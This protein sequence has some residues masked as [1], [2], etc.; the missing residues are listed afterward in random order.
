MR[1][2][3]GLKLLIPW[4]EEICDSGEYSELIRWVNRSQKIFFLSWIHKSSANWNASKSA[5]FKKWAEYKEK[6]GEKDDRDLKAAF[7]NAFRSKKN[8][9]TLLV[10]GKEHRIWQILKEPIKP[11]TRETTNN[12][13]NKRKPRQKRGS[14]KNA[15][16][17]PDDDISFQE[18]PPSSSSHSVFQGS[19]RTSVSMNDPTYRIPSPIAHSNPPSP[20]YNSMDESFYGVSSP[21]FPSSP[22]SPIQMLNDDT[23]H[24]AWNSFISSPNGLSSSMSPAQEV[25]ALDINDFF[26]FEPEQFQ[27]AN[28]APEFSKP[29]A[30][31]F[32]QTRD[33]DLVSH[34]NFFEIMVDINNNELSPLSPKLPEPDLNQG[35]LGKVL[36]MDS[37]EENIMWNAPERIQL[38]QLVEGFDSLTEFTCL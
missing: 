31:Q 36:F 28:Q 2:A 37:F 7:R 33:E 16:C 11:Q 22:C 20:A 13:N 19:F 15:K 27:F 32:Y 6:S 34:Q 24:S 10:K 38:E 29:N 21:H 9:L 18:P 17:K 25:P 5:V 8:G 12:T 35:T 30:V 26:T 23:R 4:I 3:K 1:E 14:K